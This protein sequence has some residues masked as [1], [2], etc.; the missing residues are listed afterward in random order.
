MQ[1]ISHSLSQPNLE[2][3]T[4][5]LSTLMDKMDESTALAK[6]PVNQ[7]ERYNSLLD[8]LIHYGQQSGWL[9]FIDPPA[10]LNLPLLTSLG[11]NSQKILCIKSHQQL[12]KA[13]CLELALQST[14][15][16]L[17]VCSID[18]LQSASLSKLKAAAQIGMGAAI[19]L[20]GND[21]AQAQHT[22]RLH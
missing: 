22:T 6:Q 3:M 18:G 11:V 13:R 14:H 19:F 16:R 15:T 10:K 2:S 4:L 5:D 8:K 20:D 1:L 17:V 12:S 7:S 21:I 9:V